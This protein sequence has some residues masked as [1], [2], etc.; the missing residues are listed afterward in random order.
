MFW[1]G[2]S[3]GSTDVGRAEGRIKLVFYCSTRRETQGLLLGENRERR[4]V[5]SLPGFLAGMPC[6]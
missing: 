5:G 2:L 6:G 1:K 3:V 4:S